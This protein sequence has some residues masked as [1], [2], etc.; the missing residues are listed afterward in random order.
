MLQRATSAIF[1]L[2]LFGLA[3]ALAQENKF[4]DRLLQNR[5]QIA[6]QDGR[7]SGTGAPVLRNALAGAQFVLIGEDHGIAQIPQFVSTVCNL[8]GPQGFHTLAIETGPLAAEELQ[9]WI[10]H[11]SGP[12][13]LIDF[14]KK[15]PES[16]AFYNFEEEYDLLSH[17]ARTAHGGKFQLWGLDQELMGSSGLILTRILETHPGKQ[18]TEQAERLL[19]KNDEAHA[20]A[21]K[22]G[23]P[24]DIFM[25]TAS[26]DDLNRLRDLLRKEGIAT[27]QALVDALIKSRDIYQKNMTGAGDDS[28]RERALLMKSNF[29]RDYKQAAQAEGAPPKVLLKFG[30]W[31]MYKGINPLRNNDVGN[32]VTELADGQGANS[33]HIIIMGVKGSQLRFAGIGRPYQPADF[34][35]A[36]DKDSDFLFLQP[37]FANLEREGWTMFDLRG[38]RKGFHSLEPVDK[39][40]ERIIFGYD[41]MVLIPNATPS[42]QI[43]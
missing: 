19:Q 18:A 5:Y 23:S 12:A 13:S 8:L 37:M 31:H 3:P 14:E 15:F 35:L 32:F 22:T 21:V 6:F 29:A 26:D 36:E 16:I 2:V 24:G 9:Q 10:T 20:A 1:C 17:C 27:S 38:L 25:M 42:K 34:N 41:L 30:A 40:M 4:A 28:N 33:L 43:Q 7:L 39:E 11:D